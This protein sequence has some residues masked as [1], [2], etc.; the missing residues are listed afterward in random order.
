[1][2]E[3]VNEA[4]VKGILDDVVADTKRLSR[5]EFYAACRQDMYRGYRAEVDEA[6]GR[7]FGRKRPPEGL[8]PP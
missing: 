1:M 8:P 6:A 3:L 7:Y 4:Y 2:V 5:D